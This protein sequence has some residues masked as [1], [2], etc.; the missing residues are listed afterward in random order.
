[1]LHLYQVELVQMTQ[2]CISTWYVEG[3]QW[4]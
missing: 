3:N 1:L 2:M 4:A